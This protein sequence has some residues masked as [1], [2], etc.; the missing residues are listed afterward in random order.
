MASKT[1]IVSDNLNVTDN[2]IK[3][4]FWASVDPFLDENYSNVQGKPTAVTRGIF[5]GYSMP[6]YAVGEELVFR[7]RVPL[8]WD[9]SSNPYFVAC[10]SIS[11][12][13][14]IGDK[15]K[16]QLEWES[17]D[18][19]HVIPDTT[20]ETVTDE[21]TVVDGT[22][23]LAEIITFEMDSTTMVAGQCLQ[24]RLRRIAA[25]AP[26]VSNEIIVWHWDTRWKMD[27]I[28]TAAA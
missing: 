21:V 15:Y 11:A 3:S 14:D 23:Y 12:A 9:G 27:R 16:F 2:P 28:G 19:G 26:S 7:M 17:E 8:I 10:T 18:V 22:A 6:E 4:L 25:A 1:N 20:A 13:E 24:L 5:R